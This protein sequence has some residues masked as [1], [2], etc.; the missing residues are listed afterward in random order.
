MN[1]R[2]EAVMSKNLKARK[3]ENE[4][5]QKK[6]REPGDMMFN[7]IAG[8]VFV[9]FAILCILPFWYMFVL[10][11]SDNYQ[12]AIGNVFLIPKG[13]HFKNYFDVFQ[14]E[15]MLS[16]LGVTLART[17]LGTLVTVATSMWL[18][19][20]FS[21]QEFWGRGLWYKFLVV[22][23]YFSAGLIP[24]YLN[25]KNLGLLDSFWVYIFPGVGAYNIILCKTFIEGLP[26]ALEESAEID[27]AGYIT[28]F[29]RVVFPLCTPIIATITVFTAVGH[30]GNYMD[31]VLYVKD[32]KLWTLQYL[33]YEYVSKAEA[34]AKSMQAGAG[35]MQDA[36]EST[37]SSS[38]LQATVTMVITLPIIFVYPFFQRYYVK[39]IMVGAIK[40]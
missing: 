36:M 9:I 10:S 29:L 25:I 18:G 21:K 3:A 23:M 24:G 4:M 17:G 20:L 11:I 34:M 1:E 38:S 16:A 14:E 30:W 32:E 26:A 33:L 12:V 22:T 7:I 5:E 35:R 6:I 40:G 37:L 2:G 31:T 27:G 28:R 19:Y 15:R 39:G 13:I 8:I